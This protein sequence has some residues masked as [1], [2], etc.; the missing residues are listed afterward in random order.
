MTRRYMAVL[1]IVILVGTAVGCSKGNNVTPQPSVNDVIDRPTIS[2]E[3]EPPKETH[4][5]ETTKP[6][7]SKPQV[8]GEKANKLG[9]LFAIERK[10]AVPNYFIESCY[11]YDN[12]TLVV[13]YRGKNSK[14]KVGLY[15]I[16]SGKLEKTADFDFEM[17]VDQCIVCNNGNIFISS[18]WGNTFLFL[19]KNLNMLLYNENMPETFSSTVS[20]HDGNTIYYLAS[21]GYTL[22]KYNVS[23]KVISLVTTFSDKMLSIMLV[24]MTSDDT[25]LTVQY[26]DSTGTLAY[27]ILN[28]STMEMHDLGNHSNNLVTSGTMYSMADY[29]YV[30]KGY[31]ETFN[32]EQPRVLSKKYFVDPEEGSC[33]RLNGLTNTILSVSGLPGS[34]EAK[35]GGTI[36]LYN[37]EDMQVI[38]KTEINEDVLINLIGQPVSEDSSQVYYYIYA[39]SLQVSKDQNTALLVYSQ[40][41]YT[42]VLIWNLEAEKKITSNESHGLAFIKSDEITAEDNDQYA[43]KIEKEYGI[44]VFIRDKAVRYFPDFAV[45]AMYDENTTNE[46]LKLV[47]EVL[48]CYPKGFFKQMKYGEIKSFNLYLCGTLVQGSEY[49][50]SNPGGFALQYNG[51]QM[52]VMDISYTSS[53][54]TSLCHEIMHAM[55][56]RMDYLLEKGKLKASIYD[57]WLK[58]NPKKHDYRYAYM[59]ENGVEYDAVNNAAYTPYDEKSRNN[60]DNIYYIDYYA[61]TFP[62][63]D[64]A[65]IFE[66]LMMADT[67]LSYEFNSKHLKAKAIY[68]CRMIR[69]AFSSIPD[70]ELMHWERFLGENVLKPLK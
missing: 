35:G 69:A 59:D 2:P 7:I 56:S 41:G 64:R 57:N 60:V 23:T 51:S 4:P 20:A 21:D 48:S 10:I 44:K 26:S 37:A 11:Y 53:I 32:I 49:G 34:P 5:V 70:D 1:L 16:Y 28:V 19:D 12:N 27:L 50:I 17:Y 54:K 46:A 65:R 42:G 43:A 3:T 30:S 39:N 67:E 68:L 29:D 47:E 58:L 31:I 13:I 66:N 8:M 33:F 9:T 18:T 14:L 40:E 6:P 25:H 61:N 62:N 15:N 45:N 24:Q 38:K 36:R 52:V 22:Y 63:E 55:E